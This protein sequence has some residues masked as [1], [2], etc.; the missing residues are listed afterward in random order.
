MFQIVLYTA[1]VVFS[2]ISIFALIRM[3]MLTRD[4]NALAEY[5][6]LR[7]LLP[8]METAYR[9]QGSGDIAALRSLLTANRYLKKCEELSSKPLTM[10]ADAQERR[11]HERTIKHMAR[12]GLRH[13]GHARQRMIQIEEERQFLD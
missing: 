12:M 8:V 5:R 11:D 4:V 6:R 9:R 1:L 10:I 13:V 3:R 2:G 7:A